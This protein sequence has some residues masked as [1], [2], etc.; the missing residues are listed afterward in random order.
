LVLIFCEAIQ[1]SSCGIGDEEQ[2]RTMEHSVQTLVMQSIGAAQSV[3]KPMKSPD[4]PCTH[5]KAINVMF[6]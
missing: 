6:R 1:D 3:L 2:Q 5:N 4:K